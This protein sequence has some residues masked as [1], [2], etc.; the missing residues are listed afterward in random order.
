MR[1][2]RVLFENPVQ[3]GLWGLCGSRWCEAERERIKWEK[4]HTKRSENSNETK[5][6]FNVVL[7]LLHSHAQTLQEPLITQ[8]LLC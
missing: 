7:C 3:P 8:R 4:D 5:S 2:D 1:S 6:R